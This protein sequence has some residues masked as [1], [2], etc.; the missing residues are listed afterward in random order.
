MDRHSCDVLNNPE[1][2]KLNKNR[3]PKFVSG[4]PPDYFSATG[5]LWGHPVYNWDHIKKTG[6][7]WWIKR[8]RHNLGLF[9]SV[10]I[11]H[12]IGFF[13]FWQVPARAKTAAGGRWVRAPAEDFFAALFKKIPKTAIIAEDLG[14]I[15][16]RTKAF[17][18][19]NRLTCTRVLQ[20]GFDG[21]L[22]RNPHHPD[23]IN[24]NCMIYTG[25]H[26]NNT[27]RGWFKD[28]MTKE[29]RKNLFSCI[30]GR[31]KLAE[32]SWK[33]IELAAK[34]PAAILIVPM[35]DILSLG[36]EARMNTP[37]TVHGNWTWRL[38]KRQLDTAHAGKLAAMTRK[39]KRL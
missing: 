11:D 5:Q 33:M 27:I 13:H 20:F 2:F 35:Q 18:R 9:D 25:T 23:N 19:K 30:G 14:C 6:Y 38:T 17:I 10:R 37:A 39:Y 16:D 31:V 28:E 34:S 12:F 8:I 1:L 22:V 32:I 36:P 15:T 29:K 21:E 24:R 7:D 4:T 3:K 26:D